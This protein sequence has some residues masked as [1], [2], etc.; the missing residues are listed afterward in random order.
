MYQTN[1]GSEVL[2]GY[3]ECY[4]PQ[5]TREDANSTSKLTKYMSSHK[6]TLFSI[7]GSLHI[8]SKLGVLLMASEGIIISLAHMMNLHMHLL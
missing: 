4:C 5:D 6:G 7:T 2:N 8:P 1:V 3:Y